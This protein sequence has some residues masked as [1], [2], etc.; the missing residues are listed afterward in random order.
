MSTVV[1]SGKDFSIQNVTVP[2]SAPIAVTIPTTL[3][4]PDR[5]SSVIIQCRTSVAMQLT[6]NSGD[7]NY[8]TIPSGTALSLDISTLSSPC[9]YLQSASGTVIAEIIFATE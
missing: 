9:F 1:N 4:N 6:R 8:F 3:L 5:V 7:G 2:A